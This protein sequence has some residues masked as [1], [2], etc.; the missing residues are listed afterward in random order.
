MI[1]IHSEDYVYR[2]AKTELYGGELV[3]PFESAQR[4]R[5][6]LE[7]V[8][9]AD[10]G[11]VLPPEDFGIEPVL[12]V[13]SPPF[14]R[15][16]EG[17]WE[18]W[19][20][21]GYRGE[22]IASCWPARRMTEIAPAH[23][24]GKLGYYAFA[25]ET[26]ISSGTWR[27]A[28]AAA[29]VAL[30]AT[31]RVAGGERA[32]FG[33]CRP[34]GHHAA[35]DLYGG[36]CFLNNAAIS[37]QWMRDNGASRVAVLDVDFH[38]GNGTQDIFYERS[39]VLYASIH[40]DPREAFP[41][42]LGFADEIGAGPGEGFNVNLP[43]PRGADFAVWREALAFALARIHAFGAEALIVS[44]GVDTFERDPI[45]FF[46]LASEDFST[47]GN[48]IGRARLPTVFL[49]E[50]GYAVEEIGINAVNVLTGFEQA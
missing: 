34:P 33:L 43:L 3:A 5:F 39:D 50:G 31:H 23:I 1:T 16:L 21:A 13:H 4:V 44:L 32:A 46:R 47:Y 14:V 48:L 42:F 41:Y 18:E 15:F 26:S 2:N 40:G 27:A 28:R 36:Y 45:S 17:A 30:T 49:L 9:S 6:V 35:K 24:D 12:K 29:N 38:H 37:A 11:K 19:Q 25:A 10:L 7:R 22:A 8:R 20:A